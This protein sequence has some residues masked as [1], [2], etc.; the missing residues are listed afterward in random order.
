[1]VQEDAS[2]VTSFFRSEKLNTQ[3]EA[4]SEMAKNLLLISAASKNKFNITMV[5]ML[6]AVVAIPV[7]YYLYSMSQ[8]SQTSN[9]TAVAEPGEIGS[10]KNKPASETDSNRAVQASE[11]PSEQQQTDLS[12]SMMG[13]PSSNETLPVPLEK[14]LVLKPKSVNSPTSFS[15]KSESQPVDYPEAIRVSIKRRQPRVEM[16]LTEAYRAYQSHDFDSA[17]MFYR[18]TLSHEPSNIDALLGLGAIAE[19]QS[20]IERAKMYFEKAL[21]VD[22]NNSFARTALIRLQ[23]SQFPSDQESHY[24]TLIEKGLADAG[25]YAALGSFYA[26]EQRW[27]EAQS[28]YFDAVQRLPEQADYK[29]N[30]AVSLDHL[31]KI[32]VALR[33][34]RQALILSVNEQFGFNRARVEER[35][36]QLQEQ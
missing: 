22:G 14:S 7:T 2:A 28:A 30:L 3:V 11:A 1:M 21:T 25:T 5:L 18:Q 20:D 19:Q 34:Y 23:H 16:Y 6:L 10:V 33:Y 35:I 17:S 9:F 26:S 32:D 36:G 31:G 24:K 15:I 4:S 29:Y 12:Y 13:K 8:L 27:Q